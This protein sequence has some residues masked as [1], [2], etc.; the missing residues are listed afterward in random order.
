MI[1]ELTYS[2]EDVWLI[3]FCCVSSLLALI[4]RATRLQPWR[5][6]TVFLRDER[7]A[8]YA[9]PYLMTFP[10]Y[11][12]F[13]LWTVQSTMIIIVKIGVMHAAHMSARSAVVWRPAHPFDHTAGLTKAKQEAKQAAVLAIVPYASGL[14][15]H[16]NL[17]TQFSGLVDGFKYDLLYRQLAQN[18]EAKNSLANSTFLRRKYQYASGMTSVELLQHSNRFNQALSAEVSFRM[19]IHIPGTGRLLGTRD[20][21]FGGYYRDV[22][23]KATLPLETADSPDGRLGIQYDSTLL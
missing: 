12:F 10:F 9:L 22:K 16:Q 2:I 3:W 15:G 5:S 14:S 8:S 19:P 7:G 21:I 18:S 4:I 23:A 6:L 17:K 20:W 1:S 13:V 11:M